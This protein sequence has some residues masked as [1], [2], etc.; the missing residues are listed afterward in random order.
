MKSVRLCHPSLAIMEIKQCKFE[1]NIDTYERII[2]C[3]PMSPMTI[4]DTDLKVMNYL[5]G[6]LS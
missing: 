5:E 6:P 4:G 3:A 2:F 1:L